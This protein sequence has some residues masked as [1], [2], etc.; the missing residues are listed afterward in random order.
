M[1]L[2][3]VLSV[4]GEAR[5]LHVVADDFLHLVPLDVLPLG[6]GLLGERIAG[7]FAKAK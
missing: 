4:A 1:L 3:P 7:D 6:D 5:V 2:D